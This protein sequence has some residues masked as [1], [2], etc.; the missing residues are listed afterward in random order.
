MIIL[1]WFQINSQQI[2]LSILSRKK[3]NKKLSS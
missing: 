2:V 1:F 3:I